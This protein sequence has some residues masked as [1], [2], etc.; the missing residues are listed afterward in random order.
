[1][2]ST[3]L[4]LWGTVAEAETVEYDGLIEP[5]RTVELGAPS[6][7]IVA[8]VNVDRGSLIKKGEI[9]VALDSSVEWAAVRKAKAVAAFDGEINLQ[10]AQQ[11]FAIRVHER[12]KQ[13]GA[14]STHDKDQAATE[15]IL[16]RHR[17]DK[18][19]EKQILG[20]LELKKA[21]AE[22]ARRSIK[23]PL[24]GVVIERYVNPGEYINTQPLLRIAQIDPLLVE[25]IVPAQMFG[26]IS[27]DMTAT[28]VPEL[29]MY[30]EQTATVKLIDKVID[31]ASSTFGVQLE[32]PN[33]E[34]KMPSG[35]KCL[36]KFEID[37][38]V[39]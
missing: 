6:E 30:E 3:S 39:E 11:K 18:A 35:L 15:I 22:L 20:E 29:A 21:W 10:Q 5:Y 9:L 16:T 38:E 32:L 36:V 25:V 23:S 1:L 19:R 13:V 4:L 26:K 37:V 17:L 24:N 7:G 31:A 2:L 14:I 33:T 12:I 27:P 34:L 28:I 8:K